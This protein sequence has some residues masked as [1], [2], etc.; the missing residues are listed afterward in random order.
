VDDAL[1]ENAL[2][3]AHLVSFLSPSYEARSSD[4]S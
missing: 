2:E 4:Y 3:L 1:L